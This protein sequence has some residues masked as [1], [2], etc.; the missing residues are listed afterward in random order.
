MDAYHTI[1]PGEIIRINLDK[2]LKNKNNII[3][4]NNKDIYTWR[5]NESHDKYLLIE[6]LKDGE[7]A[8]KKLCD[9][10]FCVWY[11]TEDSAELL[12]AERKIMKTTQSTHKDN[13]NILFTIL[14]SRY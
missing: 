10:D 7:K 4:Y 3:N 9:G 8:A 2:N 13:V 1:H 6:H 5:N 14:M 11:I 12:G